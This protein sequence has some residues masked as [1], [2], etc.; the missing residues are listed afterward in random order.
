MAS[1][2]QR[3]K[4]RLPITAINSNQA[5]NFGWLAG[6][7]L[8]QRCPSENHDSSSKWTLAADLASALPN[9]GFWLSAFDASRGARTIKVQLK[10]RLAFKKTSLATLQE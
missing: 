1:G 4:A 10:A 6:E 7:M 8:K 2:A 5:R 9:L 3:F